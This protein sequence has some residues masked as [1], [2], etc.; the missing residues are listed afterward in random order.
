MKRGVLWPELDAFHSS[1]GCAFVDFHEP[2]T[3]TLRCARRE[4]NEGA[5]FVLPSQ[6]NGAEYPSDARRWRGGADGSG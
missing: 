2:V 4:E 3:G 5:L 1:L 6:L